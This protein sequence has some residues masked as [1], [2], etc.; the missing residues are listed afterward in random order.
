MEVLKQPQY[1][2]LSV[3]HQSMTLYAV[4]RGYMD[5]VEIERVG[6][7]TNAL[8]AYMD[9]SRSSLLDQVN[10]DPEVGRRGGEAVQGRGRGLQGE[11]R[12][13]IDVSRRPGTTNRA[14]DTWPAP[15]KS[16]PRSRACRTR[17]RS[18]AR[19][20]WSRRAR[21]RKAQ[22]R[23]RNARPYAEKMRNVISHV[24]AANTEY[25]HPFLVTRD[26]VKRVGFVIVSSDRGLC[27]GLNNNL[28]RTVVQELDEWRSKGGR[29][30][31]LRHRQQGRRVLPSH[32]GERAREHHPHRRP[33]GH[34]RPRR[35]H[36]GG[37]RRLLGGQHRPPVLRLQRVRQLP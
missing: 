14:S 6:D 29:D 32:G 7:F 2:P 27:G 26:E 12:L 31:L 19:W 30:R 21:W 35:H 23:M 24:S 11:P 15:R 37:A 17:R 36:Q 1:T 9:S 18:R 16:A 20:R 10:A 8:M 4:D 28:F 5:D 22:E 33:A 34:R 13:V 3:A 25:K